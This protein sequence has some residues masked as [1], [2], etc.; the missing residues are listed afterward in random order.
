MFVN[1]PTS[2][3]YFQTCRLGK[4]RPLAK[5]SK[6]GL[7]RVGEQVESEKLEELDVD[8]LCTGPWTGQQHTDNLNKLKLYV[9]ACKQQLGKNISFVYCRQRLNYSSRYL[10]TT[11]FLFFKYR[12]PA[13]S[14]AFGQQSSGAS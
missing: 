11:S 14:S 6:D 3:I 13:L 8:Q 5:V 10:I 1:E 9:Y 4:H 7:I 12:P 2:W